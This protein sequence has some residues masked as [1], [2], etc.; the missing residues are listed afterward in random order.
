MTLLPVAKRRQVEISFNQIL[1]KYK[2]SNGCEASLR[3]KKFVH[4]PEAFRLS[5][6]L[7]L[8]IQDN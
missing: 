5:A 6:G 3:R 2:Q 4:E 1:C 7:V 8:S